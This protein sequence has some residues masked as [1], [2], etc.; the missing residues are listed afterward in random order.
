MRQ[1]LPTA[2]VV[3]LAF[4]AIAQ[5]DPKTH[6]L[7]IEAKDYTGCVKTMRKARELHSLTSSQYMYVVISRSLSQCMITYKLFS[8]N[9]ISQFFRD[10]ISEYAGIS[11]QQYAQLKEDL[12]DSFIRD[13][14][15]EIQRQGGC[16]EIIRAVN[17][18]NDAMGVPK[19]ELRPKPTTPFEW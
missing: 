5:V 12:G 6:R 19:P 2:V 11:L 15:S 9:K 7:C 10:F 18:I 8:A 3:L 16:K 1:L 17:N 13:V 4:P 14:S